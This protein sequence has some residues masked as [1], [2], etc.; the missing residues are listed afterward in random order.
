MEE[1]EQAKVEEEA[2]VAEENLS[3]IS[4]EATC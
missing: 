2:E 4:S 3:S 1:N